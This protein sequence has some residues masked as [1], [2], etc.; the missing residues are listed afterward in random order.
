MPNHISL[1][2][3]SNIVYSMYEYRS[4][5]KMGML[6]NMSLIFKLVIKRFCDALKLGGSLINCQPAEN[7]CLSG[8]RYHTVVSHLPGPIIE[9]KSDRVSFVWG[10]LPKIQPIGYTT[11]YPYREKYNTMSTRGSFMRK[12][13]LTGPIYPY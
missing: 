11:T 4:I 1:H 8:N 12:S 13:G 5:G 6:S 3:S 10:A 9:Q 7:L 2:L